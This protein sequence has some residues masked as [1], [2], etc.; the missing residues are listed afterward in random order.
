[1]IRAVSKARSE[2]LARLR[3]IQ[4]LAAPTLQSPICLARVREERERRVFALVLHAIVVHARVG[5][6]DTFLLL[7]VELQDRCLCRVARLARAE[8]LVDVH[9]AGVRELAAAAHQALVL[10]VAER[11][12]WVL[13]A[14]AVLLPI[15]VPAGMLA[16]NA[17]VAVPVHHRVV[18]VGTRLALAL[19]GHP[20]D[21]LARLRRQR[22]DQ[23]EHHRPCRHD[24]L[25]SG[26]VC[27]D[28][29]MSQKSPGTRV[30]RAKIA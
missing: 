19:L 20:V 5:G 3:R 15:V 10:H 29:A 6:A 9:G 8:R 24:C 14:A 1:M 18:G 12:I 25:R 2:L 4:L 27:G 26:G 11:Q 7:L 28:A 17:L 23:G 22:D 21:R 16:A 13:C 30:V